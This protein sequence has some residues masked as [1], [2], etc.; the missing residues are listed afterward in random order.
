MQVQAKT[1]SHGLLNIIVIINF[2]AFRGNFDTH[3]Q[4]LGMFVLD[5]GLLNLFFAISSS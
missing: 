4:A 1:Y 3:V 5:E 2:I